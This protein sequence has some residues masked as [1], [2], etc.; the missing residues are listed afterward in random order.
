[1]TAFRVAPTG[2]AAVDIFG[3]HA[4]PFVLLYENRTLLAQCIIGWAPVLPGFRVMASSIADGRQERA[5]SPPRKWEAL[6]K[7]RSTE[8]RLL[9]S[10][11][12]RVIGEQ[13]EERSSRRGFLARVG[14]VALAG[15]AVLAGLGGG[16][17]LA[18]GC[19]QCPLPCCNPPACGPS[20]MD[21][22]VGCC[23]NANGY[24]ETRACVSAFTGQ[25]DCYYVF[26]TTA[27][28][29]QVPAGATAP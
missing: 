5:A 27:G 24:Y 12:V 9:M 20:E 10:N 17:A 6:T 1:M 26:A 23:R 14:K 7:V 3:V 11:P 25:V 22:Y 8:R 21:V 16:A 29:P 15:G 19:G 4:M 18:A 13:L 2:T 28:C